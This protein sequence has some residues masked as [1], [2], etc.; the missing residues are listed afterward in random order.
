MILSGLSYSINEALYRNVPIVV[1]PLPYLEEIGVKDGKNAY[2]LNFDC[3]NIDEVAE[4][5]LTIPKFIF[6][7]LKDN[8]GDIL[9]KK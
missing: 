2:I 8:Y 5:M 9:W 4:K 3:S 1:T 6:K 7:P